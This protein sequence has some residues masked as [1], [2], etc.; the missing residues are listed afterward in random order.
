MKLEW[1]Y[2]NKLNG[3]LWYYQNEKWVIGVVIQ[4]CP[5][6][7]LS[8]WDC[9]LM[10]AC[11]V[12]GIYIP[13]FLSS[14]FFFSTYF[15]IP[16]FWSRK[17]WWFMTLIWHMAEVP[18]FSCFLPQRIITLV[19]SWEKQEKDW[20]KKSRKNSYE[21]EISPWGWKLAVL[22][23]NWGRSTSPEMLLV[24][25]ANCCPPC[26][27]VEPGQ[28]ASTWAHVQGGRGKGA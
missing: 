3:C 23:W 24:S 1:C 27:K 14:Q 16:P 20:I 2:V 18:T 13:S 15:T 5:T 4:L 8:L 9:R 11:F 6:K 25:R 7:V 28:D 26:W 21:D 19:K 22:K 10:L 17:I 12:K